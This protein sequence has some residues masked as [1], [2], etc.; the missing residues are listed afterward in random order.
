MSLPDSTV[1]IQALALIDIA[2]QRGITLRAIGGVAVTLVCREA[3]TEFPQLCRTP[4]DIDL[5]GLSEESGAVASVA[6]SQGFMPLV[7]FNFVNAGERMKFE[8][9]QLRL[10]V[11]LDTFRMCHTWSLRERLKIAS[12]KTVSLGDLILSKLQV[13]QMAE[14]D[15]RDLAALVITLGRLCPVDAIAAADYIGQLAGSDW[16]LHFTCSRSLA[17]MR[18]W[19]NSYECTGLGSCVEPGL[20]LVASGIAHARKSTGWRLRSLLGSRKRWYLLPEESI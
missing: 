13:V 8:S 18:D 7:E 9:D 2:R 11:F 12:G 17:S 16:G 4:G 5:V 3:Y 1:V 20:Q 6:Q 19:A 15:Y 10:D 14:K